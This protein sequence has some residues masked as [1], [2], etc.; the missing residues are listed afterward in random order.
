MAKP[1]SV[2]G[3]D[4]GQCALKALRCRLEDGKVVADAFDYIE[5]PKIL[6]QPESDPEQLVADALEQFMSRNDVKGGKVAISLPGQSGLARFFKPPPVEA[7]KIPE[8]VKYEARQQ[9]PFQLDEVIWDYQQMGGGVDVDGVQVDSEVGLFAMKKEQVYHFLRPYQK[10]GLELDIV[11]LAPFAI[12]NYVSTEVNPIE[13]A[14]YDPSNPPESLVV[15]SMGTETTDLVVTNGVRVWQRSVPI[16]GNHF[17]KQLTKELKLTFAK[18][19]QLKRNARKA[20]DPKKVFQAMRPVFVDLVNEIQRTVGFFQNL[21][22]SAKIKGVVILGNTVKLP[23]LQEYLSKNLGYEVV[24]FQGFDGVEKG[25]EVAEAPTFKDN[26]LAYSVAYGLCL[27][28]L[29][30]SRLRTNL[31]P[32]EILTER[33]VRRKKPWVVASLGALL[34]ACTMNTFFTKQQW[35]QVHPETATAGVSWNQ[36]S[37]VVSQSESQ[38]SGWKSKF[39]GQLATLN[40][41][42]ELGKEVVGNNDRRLLWLEVLAAINMALPTTPGVEP[43]TIPSVDEVPFDKRQELYIS[44]VET[45]HYEDLKKWFTDPVKN[46]YIQGRLSSLRLQETLARGEPAPETVAPAAAPETTA[47][48]DGA[49]SADTKAKAGKKAEPQATPEELERAGLKELKGPEGPGWVIELTAHHFFNSDKRFVGDAHVRQKLIKSLEKGKISLPVDPND[50][51][52]METFTLEELGI[53]FVI[54]AKG[55]LDFKARVKNPKFVGNPNQTGGGD[56]MEG[57]PSMEME[58]GFNFSGAPKRPQKKQDEEPTEP[59]YL[60][61]PRYDFI[62]QMVWQE[63]AL[64]ERLEQL[65]LKREEEKK[66][67]EEAAKLAANNSGAN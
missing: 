59:P 26:A 3:V 8:I 1:T 61:V 13:N 54:T 5:Y 66:K 58:G 50:P 34:M 45:Q 31:I 62:V 63:K 30:R 67:A 7:K 28:G 19:E 64:S 10:A 48:A 32:R 12:Y 27:Q 55:K 2:W 16:G 52:T 39:N 6:S 38:A 33:L 20:E 29:G 15:L 42:T 65:R 60:T 51:A 17:T 21:D 23:G 36:A 43:G 46:I 47:A 40:L 24:K 56:M 57:A 4:L 37:Q 35:Q 53:G 14:D 25:G 49:P 22:R 18:A 41:L 9:I 44:K 11:Q